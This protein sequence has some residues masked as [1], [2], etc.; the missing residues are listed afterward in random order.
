MGS[1]CMLPSLIASTEENTYSLEAVAISLENPPANAAEQTLGRRFQGRGAPLRARGPRLRL[2]S[3]RRRFPS[4]SPNP[5]ASIWSCPSVL[6][7]L[8]VKI[9]E[10]LRRQTPTDNF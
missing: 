3:W 2:S 8:E 10:R 6:K 4:S 9:D 5:T 1:C 7:F